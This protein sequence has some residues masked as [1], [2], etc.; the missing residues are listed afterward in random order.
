MTAIERE[1]VGFN[2][3]LQGQRENRN[4]LNVNV[5]WDLFLIQPDTPVSKVIYN[6]DLRIWTH[7]SRL[8]QHYLHGDRDPNADCLVA[9]AVASECNTIWKG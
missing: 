5:L 3:I 6:S 2:E 1:H 8:Q 7:I 9:I 4:L